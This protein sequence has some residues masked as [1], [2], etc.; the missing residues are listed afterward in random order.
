[1]LLPDEWSH[2]AATTA[3]G[4]V[5]YGMSGR[6]RLLLYRV[7][8]ETGLRAK[9]LREL[10]L[11]SVVFDRSRPFITAQAGTTKNHKLAKQY[12][13]PDLAAELQAH[14][15]SKSLATPKAPLFALPEKS[16]I[17]R[18]LY[19]DLAA[20]R[21]SWL[22]ETLGDLEAYI[23]REQTD[24]LA[25]QSQ[26]WP[27]ARLPRAAPHLRGVA[28]AEWRQ[29][30]DRPE[31]DEALYD[32][33]HARHLRA[34]AARSGSRSGSWP[35]PVFPGAKRDAN[36]RNVRLAKRGRRRRAHYTAHYKLH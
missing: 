3:C 31:R 16:R 8:I 19:K 34:S 1:M 22:R 4:P 12:I 13:R 20:A 10:T 2:L 27:S 7:A 21:Q 25:K 29:R 24:F 9:E 17:A 30:E 32:P 35:G 5:R 28:R 26:R 15:G 23:A 36:D 14:I 33:A 6:E 18:M 11:G